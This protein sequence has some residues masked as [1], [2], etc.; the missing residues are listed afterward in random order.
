MYLNKLNYEEKK[1]FLEL[2]HY[3]AGA[4]GV[5]E[6]A[7]KNMIAQYCVEME[8][9]DISYQKKTFETIIASFENSSKTIKNI[10]MIEII[11]LCM[12]DGEYDSEETGIVDKISSGLGIEKEYIKELENDLREYYAVVTKMTK[13][14]FL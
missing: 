2:A 13:H 1:A 10:I 5:V 3:V 4:N 6:D 14:V 7:E 11:G 12:S 8:I 9:Q